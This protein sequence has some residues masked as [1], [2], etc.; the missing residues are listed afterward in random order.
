MPELCLDGILAAEVPGLCKEGDDLFSV[1][2]GWLVFLR[3]DRNRPKDEEALPIASKKIFTTTTR[4]YFHLFARFRK[5]WDGRWDSQF[6]S[7][8]QRAPNAEHRQPLKS[9]NA[10]AQQRK[11]ADAR[12]QNLAA[13][14]NES[15]TSRNTIIDI[16][17]CSASVEEK[18]GPITNATIN[19][20]LP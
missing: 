10:K 12:R 17:Q 7:G 5:S 8:R 20:F 18:L 15:I 2:I 9:I 4:P 13:K 19:H 11:K 1:G 6:Q 14:Y 3:A 16:L